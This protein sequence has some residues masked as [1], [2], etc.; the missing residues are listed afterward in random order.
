MQR[1]QA[2]GNKIGGTEPG[3]RL[4]M[5]LTGSSF[6]NQESWLGGLELW[7]LQ[8]RWAVSPTWN[9]FLSTFMMGPS[10]GKSET[11]SLYSIS[12]ISPGLMLHCF[13]MVN[14]RSETLILLTLSE[15]SKLQSFF[16]ECKSR[17]NLINSSLLKGVSSTI[18]NGEIINWL[19][20]RP[21][22]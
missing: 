15:L 13:F 21:T 22:F 6:M 14:L 11:K 16:L 18:S 3:D 19:K 10:G 7:T 9:C 4:S 1:Y 2:E 8:V 20:G 5:I 12:Y 17:I